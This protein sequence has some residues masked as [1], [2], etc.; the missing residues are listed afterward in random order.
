MN[1]A[2]GDDSR[3]SRLLSTKAVLSRLFLGGPVNDWYQVLIW[4]NCCS[5]IYDKLVLWQRLVMG[6][7]SIV[8]NVNNL[9]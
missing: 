5:L 7:Q 8:N 9:Y 2:G 3:L 6:V 1:Y 4:L